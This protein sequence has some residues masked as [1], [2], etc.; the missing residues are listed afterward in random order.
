METQPYTEENSFSSHKRGFDF[1][2]NTNATALVAADGA[3]FNFGSSMP[4][5]KDTLPPGSACSSNTNPFV[6]GAFGQESRC[7]EPTVIW[8]F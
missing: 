6:F 5:P 7:K 3:G 8:K 1:S 4:G 2:N